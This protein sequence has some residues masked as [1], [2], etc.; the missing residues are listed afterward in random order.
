MRRLDFQ[1]AHVNWNREWDT[2]YGSGVDVGEKLEAVVA[3]DLP[4]GLAAWTQFSCG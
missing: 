3:V 2:G 1:N 4:G